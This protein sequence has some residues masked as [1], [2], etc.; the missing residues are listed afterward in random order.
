MMLKNIVSSRHNKPYKPVTR[1]KTK[2]NITIPGCPKSKQGKRKHGLMTRIMLWVYRSMIALTSGT[3]AV[4]LLVAAVSEWIDPRT[5]VMPAFLGLGYPWLLIAT[6]LWL[7][8]IMIQRRWHSV[9]VV[10]AALVLT[11]GTSWRILPL[12]LHEGEPQTHV[13]D[14][15][16]VTQLDTL[17]VLTLNT[18]LMGQ[19]HEGKRKDDI[20]VLDLVQASGA[21]IVCMQEYTFTNRWPHRKRDALRKRLSGTYPHSDL[22]L[23]TGSGNIGIAFYSRYPIRK[24][25]RIDQR[26]KGYVSAMYYQVEAKGRLVG[27]VNLHLQSNKLAP[28]DRMLYDEMIGHFD[29]DSLQ[30]IRTGLM[31]SLA[32]AWKLRAAQADLIAERI[33]ELHPAGMPLLVCGD[34]NDT[35]VSYVCH[36]LRNL[37]LNDTWRD[38]GF[39]L[40]ITY[41]ERRFW[42]RIDHLLHSAELHPLSI[43]V[44][45]EP[46]VSDH[47]PVQATF[48]ILPE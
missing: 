4:L 15:S 36:Q 43:R 32:K 29:A 45:R 38:A 35:P 23:N 37:G 9:L 40:G 14:G 41:H 2:R 44:H 17:N 22:Q 12:H 21:D 25:E 5:W 7:G 19:G 47:Y 30:R 6:L 42:F 18:C 8:F 34:L 24:A 20:P 28:E 10:I 39:G 31:R 27:I 11:L 46:E 33:R 1:T 26:E 48:Q 13:S 16:I 3:L